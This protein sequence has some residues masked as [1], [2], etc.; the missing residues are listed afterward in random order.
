MTTVSMELPTMVL[1]EAEREDPETVL[2]VVVWGRAVVYITTVSTE[3]PTI[4][5]IEAE[6]EEPETVLVDVIWGLAVV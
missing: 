2:V 4:V 5:L 1:V 3:L 6:R